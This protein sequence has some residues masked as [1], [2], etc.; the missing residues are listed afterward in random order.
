MT[1][2]DSYIAGYNAALDAI[3][4][5]VKDARLDLRSHLNDYLS[6]LKLLEEKDLTRWRP[7]VDWEYVSVGE[8]ITPHCYYWK[9]SENWANIPGIF[10]SHWKKCGDILGTILNTDKVRVIRPKS[11][12]DQITL[13]NV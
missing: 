4:D 3:S 2:K 6:G 10:P 5:A 8:K 7:P 13:N 1:V 12:K 11:V 9:V